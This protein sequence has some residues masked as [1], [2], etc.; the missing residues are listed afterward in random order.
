MSVGHGLRSANSI[1]MSERGHVDVDE[2]H[3]SGEAGDRV[4]D[5]QLDVFGALQFVFENGRMACG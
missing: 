5:A 1:Q 3:G 2:A 4:R